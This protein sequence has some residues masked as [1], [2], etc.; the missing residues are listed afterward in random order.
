MHRAG[1]R[2]EIFFDPEDVKAGIVTCGGLCPGLND[3]IRQACGFCYVLLL[4]LGFC[5]F[6]Q[7]YIRHMLVIA[8]GFLSLY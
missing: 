6:S 7:L 8:I 3:V 5:L 4:Y 2:K 1:P